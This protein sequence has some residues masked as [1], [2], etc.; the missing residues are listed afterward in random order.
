MN[1]RELEG[2]TSSDLLLLDT[3]ILLHALVGLRDQQLGPRREQIAREQ[4][5]MGGVHWTLSRTRAIVVTLPRGKD[6]NRR[7]L[8]FP[9]SSE[10]SKTVTGGPCREFKPVD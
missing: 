8:P 2:M 5:E 6:Q 3:K 7:L 10:D 1:G 9:G 4:K